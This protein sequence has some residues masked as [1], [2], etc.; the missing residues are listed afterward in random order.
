MPANSRWDLIRRLRV[1][2]RCE[3][4][5]KRR[6]LNFVRHA[7]CKGKGKYT[8]LGKSGPSEEDFIRRRESFLL[9]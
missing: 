5:F 9:A 3:D 7:W 6:K 2:E 1:K 8:T 4:G